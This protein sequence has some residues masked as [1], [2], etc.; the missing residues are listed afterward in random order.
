MTV[1]YFIDVFGDMDTKFVSWFDVT[2]PIVL[3]RIRQDVSVGKCV[4]RKISLPRVHTSCSSKVISATASIASLLHRV[5]MPWILEHTCGSWLW[6]VLKNPARP[7]TA[8]ALADCC[9]FGSPCRK[10]TLCLVGNDDSI[11]LHGGARQCWDWWT[12]HC[13]GTKHVQPKVSASRSKFSSSRDHARRPRWSRL[14][15]FSP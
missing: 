15:W 11:D 1:K 5:R 9:V 14:P 4:A 6:D 2:Q 10:R 7:C 3:S 8:W 13:D 12:L